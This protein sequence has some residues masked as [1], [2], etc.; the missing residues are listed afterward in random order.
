MIFYLELH[1]PD[2]LENMSSV[3]S[4]CTVKCY[5]GLQELHNAAKK[6]SDVNVCMLFPFNALR[7]TLIPSKLRTIAVKFIDQS[8]EKIFITMKTKMKSC[9][10]TI[11]VINLMHSKRMLFLNEW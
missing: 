8:I 2:W 11:M 3:Y 7:L 1:D 6:V 10:V 5:G 4:K 9:P